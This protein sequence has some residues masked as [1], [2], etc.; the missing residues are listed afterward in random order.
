M[1]ELELIPHVRR[2]RIGTKV[3]AFDPDRIT[4]ELLEALACSRHEVALMLHFDHPR[5]LVAESI[6]TI[7]QLDEVAQLRNQCPILRGINDNSSTLV[8]LC[9]QLLRANVQPY[10]F[11]Q[12]RPTAG[13]ESF[14]LSLKTAFNIYSAT[15]SRLSGLARPRFAAST[16]LGKLEI[17][18][19]SYSE[20]IGR[21]WRSPDPTRRMRLF[22]QA[23]THSTRWP[24]V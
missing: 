11:F 7:A 2:V 13:N 8:D 14:S 19:V 6:K 1:L 5:E 3:P 24:D 18:D 20:L 9:N 22:R 12:C 10:Y 21:W 23:I 4:S 17:L 15:I 16:R